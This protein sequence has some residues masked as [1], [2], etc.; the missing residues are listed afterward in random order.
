MKRSI[1]SRLVRP[2]RDACWEWTGAV[3][4]RG[5]GVVSVAGRMVYV[6][7]FMYAVSRGRWLPA[8]SDVHHVCGNKRCANPDHLERIGRKAHGALTN[9]LQGK[10]LTV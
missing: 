4:D 3:N 8:G 9:R 10:A 7:R 1:L 6:H 5:Y 2:G